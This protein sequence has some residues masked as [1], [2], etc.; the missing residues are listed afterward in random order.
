MN[1]RLTRQRP[2][3]IGT[4]PRQRPTFIRTTLRTISTFGP[5]FGRHVPLSFRALISA[6]VASDL[7]LRAARL[8]QV[9]PH[10]HAWV[11]PAHAASGR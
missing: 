9:R 10:D 5:L 4:V 3:F 7:A 6:N 1:W 11:A 2:T 8:E